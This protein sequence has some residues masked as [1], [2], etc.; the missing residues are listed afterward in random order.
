MEEHQNGEDTFWCLKAY[1]LPPRPRRLR[2][3]TTVFTQVQAAP[4]Q[5][6]L[7]CGDS[8]SLF[9]FPLPASHEP[10]DKVSRNRQIIVETSA[11][12]LRGSAADSHDVTCMR[13]SIHG[14]T[15]PVWV[16]I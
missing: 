14:I 2:K 9:V 16:N 5:P 6:A 11:S 8:L 12:L 15:Y 7:N 4:R 1:Q 13:E 3:Q 10:P